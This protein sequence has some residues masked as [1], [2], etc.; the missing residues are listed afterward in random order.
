MGDNTCRGQIK[1]IELVLHDI[2][3]LWWKFETVSLQRTNE[4]K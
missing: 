3:E 1:N 2:I 4:K